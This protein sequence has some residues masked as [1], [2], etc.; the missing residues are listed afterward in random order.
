MRTGLRAPLS[1][2]VAISFGLLVLLGLFVPELFD[3]RNQILNWAILLAACALLL[4]LVN[5]FQ[6]HWHRI[7]NR[8]NALYSGVLIA[9]MAITFAITLF[10]GS[11][12]PLS[13]WIFNNIQVP[14]ETSLMAVLAVSLT[15]A[16]ARLLQRHE[17]L[18][19]IVFLITLFVLLLGAGPL[20]GLELPYFTRILAPYVTNFLST[21][22]MR[23]LL[24]GVALGTVTTGL[25]I[26]IG[27][28]RPYGG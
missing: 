3:L 23:G 16:A 12:A 10:L 6:V 28:D 1:T 19:S 11:N 22:A 18:M 5:L 9:A 24:I 15:L 27:A 2:A 7:R 14:V 26:L 21:G 4:G 20:F 25:R 8:Q 13:A 17:D